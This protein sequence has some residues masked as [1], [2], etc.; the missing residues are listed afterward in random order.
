M[1]LEFYPKGGYTTTEESV[2][3]DNTSNNEIIPAQER[4]D[5]S[6]CC[7]APLEWGGLTPYCTKCGEETEPKIKGNMTFPYMTEIYNQFKDVIKE[8]VNEVDFAKQIRGVFYEYASGVS[9]TTPT[10]NN[11]TRD[12]EMSTT[13]I[14]ANPDEAMKTGENMKKTGDIIRNAAAQIKNVN[15]T[16]KEYVDTHILPTVLEIIKQAENP[17]ATKKELLE[18][19]KLQSK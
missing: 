1:L 18:F 16:M 15:L 13:G 8:D 17:R 12:A 10:T 9:Q 7:G 14:T 6:E 5:T 3:M 11:P 19:F 4:E 2:P